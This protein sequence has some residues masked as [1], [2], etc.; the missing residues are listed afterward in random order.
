VH[1]AQVNFPRSKRIR[2]RWLLRRLAELAVF[3]G[4]MLFITN[5]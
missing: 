5:Q 2:K 1:A 4:I 3:T